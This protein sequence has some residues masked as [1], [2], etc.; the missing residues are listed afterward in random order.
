MARFLVLALLLLPNLV[1][2]ADFTQTLTFQG[3]LSDTGAA[4]NGTYNLK[5]ELCTTSNCSSVIWTELHDAANAGQVTVTNGIFNAILGTDTTLVGVDLNQALWIRVTVDGTGSSPSYGSPLGIIPLGMV[6]AAREADYL[7]GF[8]SDNFPTVDDDGTVMSFAGTEVM[9]IDG[10]QN[11]SIGVLAGGKDTTGGDNTY[12]GWKAGSMATSG[13]ALQ[14]KNTFVGSQAGRDNTSGESNTNIGAWAGMSM[15]T[16]RHNIF[17]GQATGYQMVTGDDNTFLGR[18]AG[19]EKT[20]GSANTLVGHFAGAY[21]ATSTDANVLVGAAA[22]YVI[23]VGSS[24]FVG[25][26]SGFK[27]TTGERNTFLGHQT[28]YNNVTGAG[29]IMIGYQAGYSNT[30]SNKLYIENS[31]SA[32]PLIYGEFDNDIVRINGQAQ[33]TGGITIGTVATDNLIDDSSNGASSATLYIG[34]ETIDTTVSDRRL[35]QNIATTQNSALEYLRQ[36]NVVEFDWLADNERAGAGRVPFGLIAQDVDTIA[37]QY[38]REGGSEEDYMSVRFQ[39]MVPITIKAIQELEGRVASIEGRGV[40]PAGQPMVVTVSEVPKASIFDGMV[41]VF[42]GM[43]SFKRGIKAPKV[44]TDELCF[45][46]I[47]V[48]R[49][50]AVKLIELIRAADAAQ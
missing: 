30:S 23:R 10:T 50:E 16:G 32:T 12:V 28:G 44:V 49:D 34:N 21:G 43:F 13:A 18:A 8:D 31:S 11:F 5:F 14:Y 9:N 39:D 26:A 45:E 2:G 17:L 25:Q 47:C 36:F 4:A 3:K 48:T 6:P 42:E 46:D 38:V 22:G 24:V 35:K 15:T 20:G 27:T 40:T 7:D 19:L 1:I 29:N 37:P 33:A 41:E